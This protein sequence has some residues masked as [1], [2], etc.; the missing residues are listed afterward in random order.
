VLG[1]GSVDE[2]LALLDEGAC[3]ILF[4][5]ID[6]A[7]RSGVDLARHARARHPGLDVVFASGYGAPERDAAGF[8]FDVVAK[9]YRLDD[10]RAMLARLA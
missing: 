10:L 2:A 5:D 1:A 7:G 4:T 8:P 6:L 3:D 9:P